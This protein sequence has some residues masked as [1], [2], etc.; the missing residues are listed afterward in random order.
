MLSS[1]RCD[2]TWKHSSY[3]AAVRL[4]VY[5]TDLRDVVQDETCLHTAVFCDNVV[6]ANWLLLHGADVAAQDKQ[7]SVTSLQVSSCLAY[8]RKWLLRHIQPVSRLLVHADLLVHL[9]KYF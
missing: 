9:A 7:V 1:V 3:C 2:M 4:H 6:A 8:S 5:V